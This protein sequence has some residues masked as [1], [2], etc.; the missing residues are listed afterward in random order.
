M[1][2]VVEEEE[3]PGAGIPDE[4]GEGAADVS[5][6]GLRRGSVGVGED[7]DVGLVE[8]EAVDEAAAH[9]VDVVVAAL[10]LGLG[11]RVVDAHQQRDLAAAHRCSPAWI[12]ALGGRRRRGSPEL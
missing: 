1:A 6:R 4:A 12:A 5:P 11:A 8:A 10:E 3:V 7:S 9:A 2:A